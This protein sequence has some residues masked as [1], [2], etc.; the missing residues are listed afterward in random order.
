MEQGT[1]RVKSIAL[2]FSQIRDQLDLSADAFTKMPS[3]QFLKFQESFLFEDQNRQKLNLTQ[4]LESLPDGLRYLHWHGYPLK[5]LPPNIN[6]DRLVELEMPYSNIERL[7]EEDEVII[8]TTFSFSVKTD[9]RRII[10][11]FL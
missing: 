11:M 3:L 2:K 8:K 7:W 5:A 1:D 9:Y 10:Y 4:G 6:L